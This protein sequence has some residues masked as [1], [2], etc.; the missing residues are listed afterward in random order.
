MIGDYEGSLV[1]IDLHRHGYHTITNTTVTRHCSTA[2]CSSRHSMYSDLL[3]LRDLNCFLYFHPNWPNPHLGN[4]LMDDVWPHTERNDDCLHCLF[5]EWMKGDPGMSDL[6]SCP[7][8]DEV[9]RSV[10]S[11][12]VY[13]LDYTPS[14]T[15]DECPFCVFLVQSTQC[16]KKQVQVV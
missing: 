15:S 8:S 14:T 3:L 12:S 16:N 11:C 5:E 1:T 10:L 6:L 7:L 4:D 2:D 9:R 13:A